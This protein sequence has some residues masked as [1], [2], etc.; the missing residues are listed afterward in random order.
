MPRT[1]SASRRTHRPSQGHHSI[2]ERSRIHDRF[3]ALFLSSA[4]RSS[5]DLNGSQMVTAD[6][7]HCL[8]GCLNT[9]HHA[10]L[11]ASGG[12]HS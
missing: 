9:L 7:V 6:A 12:G 8:R 5:I 2:G 3:A 10:T 11:I 4:S 1:D